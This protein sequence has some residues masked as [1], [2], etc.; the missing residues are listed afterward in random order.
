MSAKFR[1]IWLDAKCLSVISENKSQDAWLWTD[2]IKARR[3][4]VLWSKKTSLYDDLCERYQDFCF[5][6]SENKWLE[7]LFE[8]HVWN[9]RFEK[10]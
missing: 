10:R 1:I 5:D 7:Q 6:Q 8:N 4:S 2:S 3:D 9:D